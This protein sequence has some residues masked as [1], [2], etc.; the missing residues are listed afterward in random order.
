MKTVSRQQCAVDG[1]QRQLYC[2]GYCELHYRRVRRSGST[3]L[4]P[5]LVHQ[6][7]PCSIEDCAAPHW[8]RGLCATHYKQWWISTKGHTRAKCAVAWCARRAVARGLCSTH[9]D[10]WN[11]G[12][13]PHTKSIKE[14]TP[15]ARFWSFVDRRGADKC[16]LWTGGTNYPPRDYGHLKVEGQTVLAHRFSYELHKGPVPDGMSVCHSCDTPRCVNPDHLWVGT[17]ADNSADMLAK[18][19]HTIHAAKLTPAEVRTIRRLRAEKGCTYEALGERFGV[20]GVAIRY[21]VTRK[22]WKDVP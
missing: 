15:E 8:A 11:K 10:R 6:P 19:R 3:D 17:A 14:L 20:S 4:P 12:G 13:D 2:R 5:R 18:G 1:C 22:T 7:S 21:A 16:W 9:Y